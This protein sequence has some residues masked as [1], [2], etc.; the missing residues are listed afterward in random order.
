VQPL[1]QPDQTADSRQ[2]QQPTKDAG[3]NDA[4]QKGMEHCPD[5]AAHGAGDPEVQQESSV[6]VAAQHPQSQRRPARVR[7]SYQRDCQFRP[8]LECQHRRQEAADPKPRHR[9][10]HPG[11]HRHRRH[12]YVECHVLVPD[13]C[14][15]SYRLGFQRQ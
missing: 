4:R 5:Q 3:Q 15:D 6:H 14:R 13:E 11:D 7:Q 8:N 2:H 1:H 9:R 10:H 12:N